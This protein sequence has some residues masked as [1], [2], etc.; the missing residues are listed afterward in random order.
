MV[1]YSHEFL[2]PCL[3]TGAICVDATLGHGKD[4]EFFLSQNVNKVIG[5]EIQEDVYEQTKN[6]IENPKFISY[7]MGHEKMDEVIHYEI[8]CIIFNFGYCPGK[9][10]SIHTKA[11]TSLLA[12]QKGLDLLKRKGRM[13]LVLYP[14]EE[15]RKEA[16]AI[17]KYVQALDFQE[18][19][20][21][22]NKLLN[23]EKS[24]Y[25]IGIEKKQ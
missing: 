3:H 13:A 16:K 22:Q 18:Y 11:D 17:E 12:I 2:S 7:L 21:I 6:K 19:V 20:V 9:D 10:E 24:P 15:G 8:D 23:Q 1:E 14:H 4:V 5:F 25:L